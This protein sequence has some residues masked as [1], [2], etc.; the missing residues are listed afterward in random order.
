[1]SDAV[2][3]ETQQPVAEYKKVHLEAP[4]EWLKRGWADFKKAPGVSLTYGGVFVFVGYVIVLGLNAMGL[5]HLVLPLSGSFILFAPWLAL[6]LYEVSRQL[7]RG[8]T[9]TFMNTCTAWK[10]SPRRLGLMAFILLVGMLVWTRVALVLYAL[11]MG[12]ASMSLENFFYEL[13]VTQE[14][15]LFL[16]AGS[17][18]GLVFACIVFLL[19]AVSVPMILDRDVGA[20]EAMG[21]SIMTVLR[22]SHVMWS[23]A[24]TIAILAWFGIVTF[25]IGLV[26]V[27]P[28]LGYASWHAYRDLVPVEEAQ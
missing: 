7:E 27:M 20:F 8:E 17:I 16:A 9:P 21:I 1:M 10:H 13:F 23:W 2:I 5:S 24:F 22:N 19:T 28:V 25:F 11:M 6:G 12:N 26:I 3:N 18:V 15:L 4:A 14:G